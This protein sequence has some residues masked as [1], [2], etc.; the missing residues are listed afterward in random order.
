M[1]APPACAISPQVAGLASRPSPVAST[2]DLLI[3]LILLWV[4]SANLTKCLRQGC[5][6]GSGLDPDPDWI[7]IQ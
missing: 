4:G 5:G 7:R 1:A 2:V 6:S 3:H